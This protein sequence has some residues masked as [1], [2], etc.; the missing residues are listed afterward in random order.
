MYSERLVPS[1][2]PYPRPRD[3]DFGFGSRSG[4]RLILEMYGV[5][6]LLINR[7]HSLGGQRCPLMSTS[8]H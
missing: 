5:R 8:V 7:L 2:S 1:I 3:A 6:I 4:A